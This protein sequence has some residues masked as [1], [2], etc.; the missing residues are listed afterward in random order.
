MEE[1]EEGR[2]E[3]RQEGIEKGKQESKA[4]AARN[5]LE[6]GFSVEVITRILNMPG[7]WVE[8]QAK[9]K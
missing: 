8:E 5:M 7:Q 6:E 1:R 2:Q 3:G 9:Q 4:E